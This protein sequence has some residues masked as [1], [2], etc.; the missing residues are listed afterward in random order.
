MEQLGEQAVARV[1][2]P[3]Q[4]DHRCAGLVEASPERRQR[5]AGPDVED[6]SRAT[7]EQPL[8]HVRGRA[9]ARVFV[10]NLQ[11]DGTAGDPAGCV[12]V[13]DRQL[14][15]VE[16]RTILFGFVTRGRGNHLE[17]DGRHP[18]GRQGGGCGTRA[19]R[20]AGG[21]GRPGA[22]RGEE[23]QSK[24]CLAHE[25]FTDTTPARAAWFSREVQSPVDSGRKCGNRI[26]SRMDGTSASTIANRSTPKP[27]PPAGGIPCS[28]ARMKSSSGGWAS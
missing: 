12:D 9:H 11:R 22:C 3:L 18:R 27:S 10:V 8:H 5:E 15:P 20:R 21:G 16:V 25:G 13:G 6:G 23:S 2:I 26:T 1:Q 14:H 17:G 24:E 28:R 19:G 4:Q 7:V